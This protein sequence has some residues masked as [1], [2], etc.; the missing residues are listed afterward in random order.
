MSSTP[1]R[2]LS[3]HPLSAWSVSVVGC[4]AIGTA[5]ADHSQM[6]S[7]ELASAETVITV[8]AS[9]HSARMS[10]LRLRGT[11]PWANG[12]DEALPVQVEVRGSEQPVRWRL[13]RHASQIG[14]RQ[15]QFVYLADSPR[16][17][18]TW[19]WRVRGG[20]RPL[21]HTNLVPKLRPDPPRVPLF[22]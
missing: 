17:R 8:E 3:R 2:R 18:L 5:H 16:L 7:A 9:A 22:P 14:S 21:E 1:I 15:I 13:D 6:I 11:A 10:T 19:R 12:A 20:Q 4:W